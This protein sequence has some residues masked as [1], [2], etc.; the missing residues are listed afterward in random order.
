MTTKKLVYFVAKN[1][2]LFNYFY[3]MEILALMFSVAFVLG[4]FGGNLLQGNLKQTQNFGN[5]FGKK[6][7]MFL[8]II[9]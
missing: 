7:S 6:A 1:C 3:S 2:L 4:R 5:S 8:D 9:T